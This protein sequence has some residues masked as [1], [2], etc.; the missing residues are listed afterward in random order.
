MKFRFSMNLSAFLVWVFLHR[1]FR[2]CSEKKGMSCKRTDATSNLI[3]ISWQPNVRD[4]FIFFFV[5]PFSPLLM[6]W[7][8]IMSCYPK[9]IHRMRKRESKVHFESNLLISFHSASGWKL[10]L[11]IECL[12]KGRC[13]LYLVYSDSLSIL[14]I[15]FFVSGRKKL[16]FNF[17]TVHNIA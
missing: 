2:R 9:R 10:L 15:L 12:V 1:I 11:T 8:R 7:L 3:S 16:D 13:E 6:G 4:L 17:F 14:L 5:E